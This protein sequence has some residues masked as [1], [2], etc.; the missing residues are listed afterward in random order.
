MRSIAKYRPRY[1]R[2]LGIYKPLQSIQG[3]PLNKTS[4]L[5]EIDET[6][7]KGYQVGRSRK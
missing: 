2:N 7:Q 5:T 4:K 6:H 1:V 3:K